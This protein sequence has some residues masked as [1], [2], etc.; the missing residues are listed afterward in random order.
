MPNWLM[1]QIG[2]LLVWLIIAL[3]SYYGGLWTS[4]GPI[5][6]RRILQFLMLK[7][8]PLA[9]LTSSIFIGLYLLFTNSYQ[10]TKFSLIMTIFLPIV[11]L[12]FIIGSLANENSKLKKKQQEN[13][14]KMELKKNECEKWVSSIF[15]L[16]P[17]DVTIKLYLSN[18][19]ATGRIIITNVTDE[20][21]E[22]IK[23]RY[24]DSIPKGIYL[25]VNSSES[26]LH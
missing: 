20:Q 16:S 7:I 14:K 8:V 3:I 11:S 6:R 15:F 5:G 26:I 9:W 24:R 12:L 18:E 22:L 21:S 2:L 25:E 19:K 10:L 13:E 4:S 17:Q 23:E 1:L